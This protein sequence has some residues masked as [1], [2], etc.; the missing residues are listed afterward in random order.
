M[1]SAYEAKRREWLERAWREWYALADWAYRQGYGHSMEELTP[2]PT[3]SW[4]LIRR[5]AWELEE[6]IRGGAQRRAG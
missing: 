4:P 6:R 1:P 3:T 5:A 2:A